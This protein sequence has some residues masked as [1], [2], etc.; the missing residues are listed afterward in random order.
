MLGL[1]VVSYDIVEDRTR[2]KVAKL[3]LDYG[4]RVQYSVFELFSSEDLEEVMNLITPLIDHKT[5]S[6][7][8]YLLCRTCAAKRLITGIDK[9]GQKHDSNY[10]II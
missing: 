5:D 3:L 4:E 10:I 9:G 8:Y 6:V 7:R 1:V 2:N